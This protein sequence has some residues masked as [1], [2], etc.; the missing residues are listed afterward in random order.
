MPATKSTILLVSTLLTLSL[1]LNSSAQ[2]A[3]Q[4]SMIED[5][6][7]AADELALNFRVTASGAVAAAISGSL[8]KTTEGHID[9]IAKGVFAGQDIDLFV[10]SDGSRIEFGSRS[11]PQSAETPAEL[12]Q[13]LVI[14][15]TRMGVLHNIANLTANLPPDHSAGGVSEWVQATNIT[16]RGQSY[17][18]DIMVSDTPSGS[19]TLNI[20]D[21]GFPAS[22]EQTVEFPGGAMT[23]LET[24]SDFVS[25]D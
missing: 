3:A 19:A 8:E 6:L 25:T 12:W 1:A 7:L 21:E 11:D 23:V 18:F 2:P 4:F 15:F 17:D 24:Y 13:A 9:L 5:K 22:R 20:D 10:S 16:H 14:G